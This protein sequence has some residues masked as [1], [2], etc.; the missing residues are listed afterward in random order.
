MHNQEGSETQSH[1]DAQLGRIQTHN[2]DAFRRTTRTHSDEQPRR[3]QMHNQDGSETKPHSDTQP[4]RIQT[5]NS[6][7][8][9]QNQEATL[10]TENQNRLDLSLPIG[11]HSSGSVLVLE[12]A[13]NPPYTSISL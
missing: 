1:S 12:N 4:G 8:I 6:D 10:F 7:A 9:R 2:Q 3:I 13:R 11:L 5:L